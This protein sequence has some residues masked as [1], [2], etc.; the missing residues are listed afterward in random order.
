MVYRGKDFL[1]LA[2]M[3]RNWKELN[4]MGFGFKKELRECHFMNVPALQIKAKFL[5]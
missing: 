4:E 5:L 2:E 1:F 3:F